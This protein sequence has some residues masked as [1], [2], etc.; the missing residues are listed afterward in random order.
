MVWV[1]LWIVG[2]PEVT[3]PYK[4]THNFLSWTIFGDASSS[5][6][7]TVYKNGTAWG[8][9]GQPGAVVSQ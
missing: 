6:I 9:P 4:S 7:Y 2:V 5:P 3:I 1:N 8:V